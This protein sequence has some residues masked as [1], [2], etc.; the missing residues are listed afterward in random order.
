MAIRC[1]QVLA[2]GIS[3]TEFYPLT[4][5]KDA[6]LALKEFSDELWGLDELTIVE[7]KEQNTLG[8]EFMENC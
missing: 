8:A 2:N 6:D 1:G 5:T 4:T 7:L 3:F